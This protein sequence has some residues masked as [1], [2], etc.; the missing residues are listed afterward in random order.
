M[1]I[2]WSNHADWCRLFAILYIII[3][4]ISEQSSSSDRPPHISQIFRNLQDDFRAKQEEQNLIKFAEKGSSETFQWKLL[5]II[6]IEFLGGNFLM[7]DC[8][9]RFREPWRKRKE[10]RETFAP[11]EKSCLEIM[12]FKSTWE[13]SYLFVLPGNFSPLFL[14]HL[15]FGKRISWTEA[16][17]S[18]KTTANRDIKNFNFSYR[19]LL[20][21]L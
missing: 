13:R 21:K 7:N 11:E 16:M 9:I 18:T 15:F 8:W 10:N 20:E 4:S 3:C 1:I 12:S 2:C 6:I 5:L 17:S 19:L 14:I